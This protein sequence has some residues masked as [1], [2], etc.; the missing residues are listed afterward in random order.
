MTIACL[1][2]EGVLVPEMWITFV[3]KEGLYDF[4]QTNTFE[5]LF[6]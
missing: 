6:P 2:M 1:D 5:L 4:K 3:K